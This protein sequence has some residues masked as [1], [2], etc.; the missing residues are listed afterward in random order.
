MFRLA[1]T[2]TRVFPATALYNETWLLRLVLDWFSQHNLQGHVL[3]FMQPDARWYSEAWLPSQFLTRPL[4]EGWTRADAVIGHVQIGN[5]GRADVKLADNASQFVVPEAKLFSPLSPG[6]ENARDFDQAA[7]TVACIAEVLSRRSRIPPDRFAS[8]GFFVLAPEK[9]IRANAF[10]PE[11]SKES[12]KDKVNK[13]VS[14]FPH[15]VRE[16]KEKWLRDWFVPTLW[17]M[18]VE[19]IA[20]EDIIGSIRN[21]DANFGSEL[22][23]FYEKCLCFNGM[24]EP[25]P[26]GS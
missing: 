8:L 26:R 20:W 5:I 1:S 15:P 17:Q 10:S 23:D 11:M 3:N 2:K 14:A 18:K 4:A 12:I 19:C 16:A 22:S 24:Q 6:V 9:Q 13:R 21:K 7:R 25:D